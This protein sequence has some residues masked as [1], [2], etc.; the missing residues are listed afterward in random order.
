MIGWR[1]PHIFQTACFGC[2]VSDGL[3]IVFQLGQFLFELFDAFAGFVQAVYVDGIARPLFVRRH[4]EDAGDVLPAFGDAV[5]NGRAAADGGFIGD[6]NVA[7]RADAAADDAV[8]ADGHAAGNAG[9]GGDDGMG[10][11]FAVV[12][13]LDLIVDFGAVADGGVAH[14]AAV[15]VAVR[16]DFHV[17]AQ[18][19]RAGLRDFEPRVAGEGKAETVRADNRAAVDFD[20]VAERAAVIN[21]SIGVQNDFAAQFAIMLDDGIRQDAAAFAQYG[22]GAD[23]GVRADFA[24]VWHGGARFD[25][26]SRMDA[27]ARFDNWRKQAGDFGKIKVR[28][29]GDNQA[30]PGKFSGGFV[31]YDDCARFAVV[32][33]VFVFR[34][35]QKADVFHTGLSQRPHGADTDVFAA[36]LAAEFGGDLG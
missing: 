23:V 36:H 8:I 21:H 29:G 33:F 10:T 17:V 9:F 15:D 11:D 22:I 31:G 1:R 7:D 3:F 25:N 32:Y 5:G 4:R 34:I 12:A 13:D 26:G 16:A 28:V 18:R 19:Y 30:A 24:A 14:G 6:F 20:A 35:G 27:A 2:K